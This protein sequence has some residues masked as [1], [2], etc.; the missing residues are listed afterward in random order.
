MDIRGATVQVIHAVIRVPKAEQ[1]SYTHTLFGLSETILHAG[2]TG[3]C[4]LACDLQV[5]QIVPDIVDV[6]PASVRFF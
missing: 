5:M 3:Q 6:F 4:F 1:L 2:Y